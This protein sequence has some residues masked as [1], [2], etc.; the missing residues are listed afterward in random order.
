MNAMNMNPFLRNRIFTD[1]L[2]YSFRDKIIYI[3]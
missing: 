1:E 3:N 2:S